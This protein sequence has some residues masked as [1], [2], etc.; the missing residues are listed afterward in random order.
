MH[1]HAHRHAHTYTKCGGFR[2]QP[3][4][5]AAMTLSSGQPGD[6]SRMLSDRRVLWVSPRTPRIATLVGWAVTAYCDQANHPYT[7]VLQVISPS[8]RGE[9]SS[10]ALLRC[11]TGL[12]LSGHLLELPCLAHVMHTQPSLAPISHRGIPKPLRKLSGVPREPRFLEACSTAS[13][14]PRLHPA[15]LSCDLEPVAS[16]HCIHFPSGF[17]A[18]WSGS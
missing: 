4:K 1:S 9:G 3:F 15:V 8:R 10:M 16:S 7:Q 14:G 17:I 6:H 18:H 11:F 13:T 5:E 2:S 12:A